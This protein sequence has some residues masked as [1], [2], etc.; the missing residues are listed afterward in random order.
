MFANTPSPLMFVNFP[1]MDNLNNLNNMD[2]MC[3]LNKRQEKDILQQMSVALEIATDMGNALL[4]Y[5]VI[6]FHKSFPACFSC[7][8]WEGQFP[9][10]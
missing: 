10:H 5:H 6:F 2:K 7:L 4:A 9:L 8:L 1:K 3:N